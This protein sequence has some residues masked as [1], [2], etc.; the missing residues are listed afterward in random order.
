M[1]EILKEHP[2]L[3]LEIAQ[4]IR[5][6]TAIVEIRLG[7]VQH[8]ETFQSPKSPILII[9]PPQITIMDRKSFST[10]GRKMDTHDANLKNR[11]HSV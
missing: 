3:T 4:F 9:F 7:R 6:L 1:R 5:D 10:L 2:E 11:C 8:T